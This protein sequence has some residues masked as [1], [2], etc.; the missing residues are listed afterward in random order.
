MEVKAKNEN[1]PKENGDYYQVYK[2]ELVV[3]FTLSYGFEK[4]AAGTLLT[5][6]VCLMI[7]K[8]LA[9]TDR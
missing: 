6:S 8:S 3:N 9:Q 4:N 1:R 5:G 7:A 2:N